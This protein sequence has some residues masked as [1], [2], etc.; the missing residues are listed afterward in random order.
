MAIL[1]SSAEAQ[2]IMKHWWDEDT[3]ATLRVTCKVCGI[4]SDQTYSLQ[5]T[6][7]LRLLEVK[8][9]CE[10]HQQKIIEGVDDD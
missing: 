10:K 7:G 9:Y 3:S 8:G 4:V 6:G 1:T 5:D 2:E